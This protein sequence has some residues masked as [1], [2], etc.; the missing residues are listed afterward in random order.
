MFALKQIIPLFCPRLSGF[1]SHNKTM[2]FKYLLKYIYIKNNSN[3]N[4][5][6][7]STN[8]SH[9]EIKIF[10][11][12]QKGETQQSDVVQSDIMSIYHS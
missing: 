7:I 5:N 6:K 10:L 11:T 2:S 4:G 8:R 3:K 1:Q 9:L 12:K